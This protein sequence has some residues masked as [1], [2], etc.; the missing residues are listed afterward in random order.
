MVLAV[1]NGVV[2]VGNNCL[3][4]DELQLLSCWLL[5]LSEWLAV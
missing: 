5:R 3:R 4:R 2:V 1:D